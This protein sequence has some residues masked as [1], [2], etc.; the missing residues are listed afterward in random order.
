MN[1]SEVSE[2]LIALCNDVIQARELNENKDDDFTRRV[3]IRSL[4]TLIEGSTWLIKQALL[5]ATCEACRKIELPALDGLLGDSSSEI[6]QRGEIVEKKKFIPISNNVRFTCNQFN[7]LTKSNIVLDVQ[8]QAWSYFL[9]SI[10]VRNRITHPKET[11]DLAITDDEFK[12]CKAV[13]SWYNAHMHEFL[14][15]MYGRR[16]P[17]K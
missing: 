17:G 7:R 13:E 8:S 14:A 9:D 11:A 16:I 3:Y 15:V 4:F 10:K 5:K 2:P 6:D 1:L 12:K